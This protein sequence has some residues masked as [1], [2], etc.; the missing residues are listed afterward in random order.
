MFFRFLFEQPPFFSFFTSFLPFPFSLLVSLL[1]FVSPLF[2]EKKKL[3]FFIHRFLFPFSVCFLRF[4]FFEHKSC[5]VPF[6][7]PLGRSVFDFFFFFSNFV[8]RFLR[9][10]FFVSFSFLNQ[11]NPSFLKRLSHHYFGDS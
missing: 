2:E 6:S 8:G 9:L 1:W 5:L 10:Q 4:F 3:R 11:T 7:F